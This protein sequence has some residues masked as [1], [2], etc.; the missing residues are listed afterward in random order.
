[1]NSNKNENNNRKNIGTALKQACLGSCQKVLAQV[2]RIRDA[3]FTETRAALG[4]R[5]HMVRLALN[6]AEAEAWQ[7]E[8][9]HLVFPVLAAEKVQAVAAWNR[10]QQSLR[11]EFAFAV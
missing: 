4:S 8:Y 9:P 7:T 5:Q 11:N 2:A 10:R 3:I 1:M 6:E